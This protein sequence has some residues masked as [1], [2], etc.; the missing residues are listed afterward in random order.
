MLLLIATLVLCSDEEYHGPSEEDV[1]ILDKD[2]LKE[3]IYESGSEEAWLIAMHAPW[4]DHCKKMRPDWAKLATRLKGIAKV[5]SLDASQNR[6]FDQIFDLKGYPTVVMVPPGLKNEKV[7]IKYDGARVVDRLEEWALEKI[8]EG[9]GFTVPRLTSE[10]AW[11]EYC[12]DTSRSVCM[13]A[14]L[15]LLADS[16]PEERKIQIHM[17]RQVRDNSF[18]SSMTSGTSPSVLSGLRLETTHKLRTNS[19]LT[20]ASPQ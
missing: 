2:N 19:P 12:V 16:S 7:F 4:C 5:A 18:R 14:L 13:V 20:P 9:K 6:Q 8:T 3:E 10:S 17:I 15:P 1:V 11:K